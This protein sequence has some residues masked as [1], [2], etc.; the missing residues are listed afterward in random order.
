MINHCDRVDISLILVIWIS[1]VLFNIFSK[2]LLHLMCYLDRVYT[3]AVHG[4]SLTV[5]YSEIKNFDMIN[6]LKIV[7]FLTKM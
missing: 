2:F 7:I 1:F 4:I 3:Q 5:L 6:N